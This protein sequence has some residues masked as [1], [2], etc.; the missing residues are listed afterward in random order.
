MIYENL[1]IVQDDGMEATTAESVGLM[2]EGNLDF[3]G[4][5]VSLSILTTKFCSITSYHS[6]TSLRKHGTL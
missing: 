5:D 2:N 6:I 3:Y 4:K 1:I